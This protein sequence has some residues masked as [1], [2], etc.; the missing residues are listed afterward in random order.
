MNPI[1]K[2]A[3]TLFPKS[4]FPIHHTFM[5]ILFRY[6]STEVSSSDI[7]KLSLLMGKDYVCLLYLVEHL[8]ENDNSN[9]FFN[10]C[11]KMKVNA[12]KL[13]A[14]TGEEFSNDKL[15]K[16]T[17]AIEIYSA[18]F[19]QQELAL[20]QEAERLK[21]VEKQELAN[22]IKEKFRLQEAQFLKSFCDFPEFGINRIKVGSHAAKILIRLQ[23]GAI[24]EQDFLWLE[25]KGFNNEDVTQAFYINRAKSH[26]AQWKSSNKPWSLVN[27]IAD[28]RKGKSSQ[29]VLG[30]V[31]SNYPFKFSK[32]NKKLNS[33]LLT[34]S[35]G[36]FR[37][38]SQYT[39]SLKLGSEANILTPSDF[40]P[41]TLIGASNILLG[42]VS[43]G[44]EWYQKA[45]ER[46]FKPDSYDNEL[47]SVYM[48][49][50]KQIQK[51]LKIDLLEKGYSFSWLK[52]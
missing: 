12:K 11:L 45:I 42:N 14:T 28:Y 21:A 1:V 10:F 31:K 13:K 8:E 5:E 27:A 39:E 36:V 26:L 17:E 20:Q 19:D 7:G 9:E 40:R 34:T 15:P 51:E 37:D 41:C 25:D 33:A 50:N 3:K 16:I 23:S 35:G 44:Y 29:E 32:G 22:R 48:R 6:F 2:K 18:A 46:G 30:V 49:C 24:N 38:L 47:R 52:C 43:E 4:N